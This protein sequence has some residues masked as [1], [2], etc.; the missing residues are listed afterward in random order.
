MPVR[1][2]PTPSSTEAMDDA[3]IDRMKGG[4]FAGMIDRASTT[5]LNLMPNGKDFESLDE[6]QASA[7]MTTQC[8]Q[9]K[10]DQEARAEIDRKEQIKK[11]GGELDKKWVNDELGALREA[12]MRQLKNER[13]MQQHWVKLGHGTYRA[14]ENE[15][16]FFKDIEA[17]ER[18][19]C[20]LYDNEADPI[21]DVLAALSREHIETMF[22]YL[23]AEKAVFM[24]QMIRLEGYPSILCIRHGKVVEM[25]NPR[26]LR[27]TPTRNFDMKK[28]LAKLAMIDD[29]DILE[30]KARSDDE[31]SEEE[32]GGYRRRG[33]RGFFAKNVM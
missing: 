13:A 32:E 9:A 4:E 19:I 25:L 17:H 7:M 22:Y 16:T 8:L 21:H 28:T 24:T 33:Q 2:D 6:A 27:S 29:E 15:R 30:A 11:Y 26:E 3:F 23:N 31:D 18:T 5:A 14:I 10:D 12:R 20:V 1:E